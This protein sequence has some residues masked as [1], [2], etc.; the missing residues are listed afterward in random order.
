MVETQH[1]LSNDQIIRAIEA[2]YPE[3]PPQH[4]LAMAMIVRQEG[5]IRQ[6]EN[7]PASA[8]RLTA[9]SPDR[10][11]IQQSYMRLQSLMEQQ[12]A[13]AEELDQ[14]AAGSPCEFEPNQIWIL[15]RAIKAQSRIVDLVIH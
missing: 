6:Q 5:I 1:T 13:V 11:C 3:L 14:L 9:E 2:E 4:Q 15:I 7:E 10:S 12:A 8:P